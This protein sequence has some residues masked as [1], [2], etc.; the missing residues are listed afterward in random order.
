MFVMICLLG[1]ITVFVVVLFVFY[2]KCIKLSDYIARRIEICGYCIL[3]VLIIW[4]FGIRNIAMD[5]FYNLDLSIIKEKLDY[6]FY[7]IKRLGSRT[8]VDN[9]CV[10]YGEIE[11]GYDYVKLQMLFVDIAELIMQVLSTL[12]IAIGRLQELRN[13]KR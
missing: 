3:L 4:E 5:E 7:G 9:L 8:S 11:D 13:K 2:F 10:Q 6:I 1:I 12:F